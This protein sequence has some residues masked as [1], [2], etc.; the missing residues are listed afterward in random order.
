MLLVAKITIGA[1]GRPAIARRD[2][3]DISVGS[4]IWVSGLEGADKWDGPALGG[5]VL[6][7]HFFLP[8]PAGHSLCRGSIAPTP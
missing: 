3:G 2:L 1:A 6:V 4:W 7:R 8:C 5:S